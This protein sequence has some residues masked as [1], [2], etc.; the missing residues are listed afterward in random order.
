MPHHGIRAQEK[1]RGDGHRAGLLG[2]EQ[3]GSGTEQLWTRHS[4]AMSIAAESGVP[5]SMWIAWPWNCLLLESLL[6][7]AF[8]C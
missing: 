1:W 6:S 4:Q 5:V 7:K 3:G 8:L 2:T